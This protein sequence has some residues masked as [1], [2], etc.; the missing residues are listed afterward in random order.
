MAPPSVGS[1]PQTR[2]EDGEYVLSRIHRNGEACLL[3][4]GRFG[5]R[6]ETL[7][8]LEHAYELRDVLDPGWA[9][10]P[11]SLVRQDGGDALLLEDPGGEVLSTLVGR[12]RESRVFLRVA[13]GIAEALRQLHKQGIVHKDV[14]PAHI[15]VDVGTGQA[16]LTGFSIASRVPRERQAPPQII[17]GSLAYMAPEQ[18]G[19]MNRS[20]DSRSVRATVHVGERALDARVDGVVRAGSPVLLEFA[21]RPDVPPRPGMSAIVA[22]EVG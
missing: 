8:R 11:R 15:L 2:W 14:K 4:R 9:T 1:S 3:V 12:P 20:V 17:A 10:R 5:E 21:T 18:T 6:P 22:V 7:A 19:R 13:L 16:W